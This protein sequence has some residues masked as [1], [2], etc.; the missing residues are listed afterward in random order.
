MTKQKAQNVVMMEK[1]FNLFKE[2]VSPI[3]LLS[4]FIRFIRVSL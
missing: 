4:N 1:H 2:D 3:Y